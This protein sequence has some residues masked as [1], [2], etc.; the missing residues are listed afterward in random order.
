MINTLY[1]KYFQ[2][3]R[4]FLFPLLGIKKHAEY[5][6]ESYINW[7]SLYNVHDY[8]L[9]VVYD[10]LIDEKWNIYKT[11]FLLNNS[12]L[13]SVYE[14]DNKIIFVFDFTSIKDDY[15]KFLQGFYSK[16]SNDSKKLITSYY[17]THTSEWVYIESYLYP[18]KH[19]Q[20]YSKLLNVD[21]KVLQEAGELCDKYN[22]DSETY[23]E[24]VPESLVNDLKIDI[25][26]YTDN[27]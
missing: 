13:E 25:S 15:N 8:K 7:K 22:L 26:L 20:E 16:L 1:T 27:K 2:K 6:P 12:F 24:I 10:N 14:I 23:K 11:K 21:E 18:D 19:I 17:G 5:I 9:I 4:T 3:S